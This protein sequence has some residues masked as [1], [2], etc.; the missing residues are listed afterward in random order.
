[1]VYF[2]HLLFGKILNS[3]QVFTNFHH[4]FCVIFVLI[5]K[6]EKQK[7]Y[8]TNEIFVFLFVFESEKYWWNSCKYVVS[9][10]ISRSFNVKKHV[11]YENIIAPSEIISP[12]CANFCYYC[13]HFL[14]THFRLPSFDFYLRPLS[15]F[16]TLPV[17]KV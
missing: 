12:N 16:W 10:S 8:W 7:P 17:E 15:Y 1:M 2:I 6:T 3:P 4:K 11:V 13:Y 14:R 5:F 9:R